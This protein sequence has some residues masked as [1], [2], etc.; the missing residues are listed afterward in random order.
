VFVG[1]TDSPRLD[2]QLLTLDLKWRFLASK[3]FPAEVEYKEYTNH[4]LALLA[5]QNGMIDLHMGGI[6]QGFDNLPETGFGL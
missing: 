5:D 4:L 1:D 6:P 2:E 3:G